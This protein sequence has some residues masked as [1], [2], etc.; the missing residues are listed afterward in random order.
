MTVQ[1][2]ID[3]IKLNL[4]AVSTYMPN[5]P[6]AAFT[7]FGYNYLLAIDPSIESFVILS[8][9]LGLR[10]Q[11]ESAY[12]GKD[13]FHASL[14]TLD[15]Y[16]IL[17]EMFDQNEDSSAYRL[18]VVSDQTKLI[19]AFKNIVKTLKTP[20]IPPNRSTFSTWF[21]GG[22]SAGAFAGGSYITSPMFNSFS[23]T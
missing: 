6:T 3:E 18:A 5:N 4:Q 7:G 8:R 20:N 23:I 15:L 13:V 12:C 11:R 2:I 14:R 16:D 22:A 10:P 17:F 21:N 9:K 1:Q 19:A